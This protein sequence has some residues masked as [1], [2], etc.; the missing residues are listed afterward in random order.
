MAGPPNVTS[1]TLNS[2]ILEAI[3]AR[4]VET[5]TALP[6]IVESFNSEKQTAKIRIPLRRDIRD[7]DGNETTRSWPILVSVPVWMP[8]AG[9]F[10]ITLP[11]SEGDE[12]LVIFLERDFSKW[13]EDG[14]EQSPETRRLH[15]ISDG[16]ALVGLNRKSRRIDPFDSNDMK[17]S[18]DDGDQAI[19]LRENGD[20][21][22]KNT[23]LGLG[24][25]SEDVLGLLDEVVSLF[26]GLTVDTI[27]GVITVPSASTVTAIKGRIDA[28]KV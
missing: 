10:H 9:G 8:H 14:V 12:C 1:T 20:I 5:H 2:V 22:V 4:M 13:Y 25:G 27:T 19:I 11:V 17:I 18:S 16:I 21:E 23:K 24:A 28:V 6:G 26:L 15:D 7:S 3:R